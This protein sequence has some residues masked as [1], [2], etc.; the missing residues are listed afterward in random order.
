MGNSDDRRLRGLASLAHAVGR[1]ATVQRLLETAADEV[2]RALSADSVSISRLEPGTWTLRTLVNAGVLGPNEERTPDAELYQLEDYRHF[3]P[4][5]RHR[6]IWLASVTDP[7]ADPADVSL[8]HE[9]DK[10]SSLTA[11]LVVDGA[12]WGELYAA[13]VDPAASS[14]T[15][16]VAHVEAV[17][18]ILGGA[19]S[20]ALHTESLEHLAFSDPLTGLANRRALDIAADK[21]FAD[22]PQ[23]G[24]RRVSVVAADIN[25]LK[26]VNDS[27]GHDH[28]DVVIK[29]VAAH[30]IRHFSGL[31]GSL[32]ARVGGDEFTVLVPGHPVAAVTDVASELCAETRSLSGG[33]ACGVASTVIRD[34]TRSPRPLFRAADRAMYRAKRERRYEPVVVSV[35]KGE[36]ALSS[37]AK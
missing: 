6:R 25:D 24:G 9:L 22:V 27:V 28:G 11:P 2:V 17:T 26:R 3:E 12:L 15:V 32:V 8:L 20:R 37:T 10:G 21:A 18:A 34:R 35:T 31:Y 7:Q 5:F 19:I 23:A 36:P 14:R 13:W 16:S 4:V 30:L 1:P 33:I 29:S